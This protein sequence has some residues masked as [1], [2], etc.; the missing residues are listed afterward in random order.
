[1][2]QSWAIRELDDNQLAL[3][4]CKD[5]VDGR[6]L[7]EIGLEYGPLLAERLQELHRVQELKDML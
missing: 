7:W 4:L 6:R 3:A 5:C 2:V 1:M